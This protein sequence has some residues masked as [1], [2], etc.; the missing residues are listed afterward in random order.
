M[1]NHAPIHRITL[2]IATSNPG[3][4][5]EIVAL[6]QGLEVLLVP[7]D[8]AGPCVVPPEGGE[9]FQE[10]ARYKAE[11]VARA[12]GSLSL[13]DDS[14]LEVDAL[15]GRPGVLSARFGGPEAT[16][17]ARNQ[18]LLEKLREVPTE[19]R[20]ARF[21][22]VVA[23]A[24]PDGRVHLAEGICQ[25]RIALAPRGTNGFG[26]DPVFEIPSL[27]QTLA[28]VPPAVK[29]RLSHR[30]QALAKARGILREIVGHRD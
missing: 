13:A 24:E 6:L 10:N 22:C 12:T 20:T 11:A 5:D 19:R 8:R 26:Y 28:E 14:G 4:L 25:G 23:I 15:A 17:A 18:L 7:L 1:T 2:V 9:S 3:K 27:G 21:R 30:G 16:D 29:N